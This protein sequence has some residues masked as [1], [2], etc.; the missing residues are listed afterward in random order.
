[1]LGAPGLLCNPVDN[2]SRLW[3]PVGGTYHKDHDRFGDLCWASPICKPSASSHR[4]QVGRTNNVQPPISADSPEKILMHGRE[5]V[6][7][8]GISVE[9]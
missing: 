1:M 6:D 7:I 8:T 4:L 2:F 3:S 9:V 5:L